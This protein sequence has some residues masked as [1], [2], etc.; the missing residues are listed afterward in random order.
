MLDQAPV[1]GP[2]E[3][4][5]PCLPSVIGS[6]RIIGQ[7]GSGTFGEVWLDNTS[8]FYGLRCRNCLSACSASVLY[9]CLWLEN[10]QLSVGTASRTLRHWQNSGPETS[11][12]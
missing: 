11:V 9:S 6:Y 10:S 3:W 8:T 12:P 4:D 1:M 5:D 7:I 2:E